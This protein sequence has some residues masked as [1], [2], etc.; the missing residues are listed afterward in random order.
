M[1]VKMLTTKLN[2]PTISARNNVIVEQ[3]P[4][5]QSPCQ[6]TFLLKMADD[7][8]VKK[9]SGIATTGLTSSGTHY[10]SKQMEPE[11]VQRTV[12]QSTQD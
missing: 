5:S 11:V 10:L 4:P 1:P 8:V 3:V 2:P 6:S 7:D 12:E 9:W